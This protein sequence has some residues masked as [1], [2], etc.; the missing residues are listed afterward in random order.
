MTLTQ[1]LG[2]AAAVQF[3]LAVRVARQN[4]ATVVIPSHAISVDGVPTLPKVCAK[5]GMMEPHKRGHENCIFCEME[6]DESCL[7]PS[8]TL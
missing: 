6:G 4:A 2:S 1:S 8:D 3:A 7:K 5:C